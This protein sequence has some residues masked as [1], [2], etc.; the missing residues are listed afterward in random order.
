[1]HTLQ[2]SAANMQV[3]EY[4]LVEDIEAKAKPC[5]RH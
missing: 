4:L 2:I 1:V 3:I 5:R